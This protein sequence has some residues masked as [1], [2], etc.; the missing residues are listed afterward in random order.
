[1]EIETNKNLPTYT[2]TVE[3][4]FLPEEIKTKFK[5]R[6]KHICFAEDSLNSYCLGEWDWGFAV[7]KDGKIIKN[8]KEEK[9]KKKFNNH[10][11]R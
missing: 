8:F 11:L 10:F 3:P 6:I 5:Q 4:C 1:M 9:S 2:V 7:V